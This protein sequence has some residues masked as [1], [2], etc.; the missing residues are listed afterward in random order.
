MGTDWTWHGSV[1]VSSH[2]L[3][4]HLK[5]HLGAHGKAWKLTM[6]HLTV[7][8]ALPLQLIFQGDTHH[9]QILLGSWNS[10]DS[11]QSVSVE[12]IA[13]RINVLCLHTFPGRLVFNL[14]VIEYCQRKMGSDRCRQFLQNEHDPSGCVCP[15]TFCVCRVSGGLQ[16]SCRISGSMSPPG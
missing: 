13:A 8:M 11:L 3:V 4:H 9:G 6:V 14:L 2:M 16:Y 7:S 10:T 5:V 1:H 15:L 12:R